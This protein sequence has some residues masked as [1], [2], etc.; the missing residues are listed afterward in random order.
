MK[1]LIISHTVFSRTNNM[2][3]TLLSYF[4]DFSAGETAQFY[5]HSE[6]PTIDTVCKNYYRFTDKDALRSV[7][8]FKGKGKIYT[9][10]DIGTHEV[11][12]R[13]D[14]GLTRAAYDIG[15]RRTG[16][17]YVLRNLLWKFSH[18]ETAEL[19]RWLK[20]FKPEIIFFAS[21]D[22]SF[23]YNI[24]LKI[25]DELAIPLVTC[26][27]DDFYLF[28]ANH[29]SLLGRIEH[30]L[31]MKTVHRTMARSSC[32]LTISDAMGTAYE[33]LFQRPCFTIDT[34]AE[35]KEL[36]FP[37]QAQDISYIGNLGLN[38]HLQLIEIGREL[39]KRGLKLDVYSTETS[40]ALLEGMNCENGICFHGALP[41]D[42]VLRVMERSMLLIHTE[43]FDEKSLNRVR[44]SVSTKIAETLMYGPCMLAYGPEE[45]ASI[46]YLKQNDAAYVITSREKLGDG[47]DELLA[48]AGLR[49]TI[50][51]NARKLAK[52]RHSTAENTAKLRCW[53]QDAIDHYGDKP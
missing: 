53:L 25:A 33:K 10:E 49:H 35:N 43:A 1:V 36:S 24:A 38:R 7:L 50:V 11:Q 52:V 39:K 42:E 45:A 16:L 46:S 28:N 14:K 20:D 8:R 31:R 3:R 27:V 26:C 47:L 13:T 51:Q 21:G 32:I 29:D 48:N 17:I 5:I 40:R 37:A 15:S 34:S 6:I 23:M 4:R 18:W 41:A 30:A 19:K 9:A 12:Q 22:Y 2:G 44:F